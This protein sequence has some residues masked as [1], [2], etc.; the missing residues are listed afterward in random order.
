MHV[1]GKGQGEVPRLLR[2]RDAEHQETG[3]PTTSGLLLSVK[4]SN[5]VMRACWLLWLLTRK[6]KHQQKDGGRGGALHGGR[7][8]FE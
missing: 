1:R 8:G 7:R 6:C 2:A 3:A 5:D 4:V